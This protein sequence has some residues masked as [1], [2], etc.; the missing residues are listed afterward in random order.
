MPQSIDLIRDFL[1][2]SPR[3]FKR[4]L[5]LITDIFI[6]SCS[7][8]L[9]FLLRNDQWGALQGNQW[10]VLITAI[11]FSLSSFYYFGHYRIVFRYSGSHAFLSLTRSSCLIGVL[12]FLIFAI[13]G[14]DGVPRSI[15]VIQPILLFLLYGTT[16]YL[17]RKFL[18]FNIEN[19]NSSRSDVSNA[20]IYGVSK[21]SR[22][23]ASSLKSNTR[24]LIKGFIDPDTS[25]QKNTIDGIQVYSPHEI[26]TLTKQLHINNVFVDSRWLLNHDSNILNNLIDLNIRVRKIRGLNNSDSMKVGI[27]QL[28]D[29]DTADL[30]DRVGN[31][32][33][34]HSPLKNLSGKVILVSGAGGSIGSELCRQIICSFPKEIVLVDISE[35]ALYLINQELRNFN[36]IHVDSVHNLNTSETKILPIITPYL[37]SIRDQELI[38]HILNKH[39][40]DT[41]FHA[42]AYKH[43]PLVEINPIEGIRNNVYGTR[44]LLEESIKHQVDH[45]ILISTDKAVRPTNIMGA[46]KRIAEMLLQALAENLEKNQSVTKM[47]MVRFG[48]VLDSSGSVIPLFKEQIQNGGPVT[49]TH[50]EVTRFFMTIPEAAN[51]VLQS[52]EIA[53]NG[54]LLMLDMG[55]PQRIY[56]L[57]KKLIFLSGNSLKTDLNPDGDIEIKFTGLRP[58][59]KLY[60][61][62]LIG[63]NPEA[64]TNA[65]IFRATEDFLPLAE[66]DIHLQSLND[67]LNARDLVLLN[68][69]LMTLVEGYNKPS[70]ERHST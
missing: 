67:A 24:V 19:K 40:P 18:I 66:L 60:E 62:L 2:K 7:V 37:A 3:L 46:S 47:S 42:A 51:L 53:N 10:L 61:E 58:G 4:I 5:M 31:N 54:D 48:N 70:L 52:T 21:D 41:V 11:L 12:S 23:F 9:A 55:E 64:T 50:P 15:G 27:E 16:H 36:Q 25:L 49:V 69:I 65:R 43:V 1:L 22:N 33:K 26:T 57:A 63:G 28:F 29:L 14:I 35:H 56:D 8:W 38:H 45:F 34:N 68:N 32:F 44:T 30:L 20:L 39:Q 13:I 59:E 17:I 6:C